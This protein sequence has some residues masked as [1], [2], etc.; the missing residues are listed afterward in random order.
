VF[1]R[2]LEDA[3]PHV[4]VVAAE[5]LCRIGESE[6]GLA[7]LSELL[8][9]HANAKV[10]LQAANALDHLGALARPALA[11][12]RSAEKDEDDY[13]KRAVRYTAAV[14]VGEEPPG[15]GE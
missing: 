9:K 3:S 15:E 2:A 12:L 13:V 7:V 4:R 11:A 10:R 1:V 6:R 14:L 8:N 5:A